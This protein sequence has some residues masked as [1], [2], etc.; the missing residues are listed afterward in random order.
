[1]KCSSFVS[2]LTGALSIVACGGGDAQ[3]TG[4]TNASAF[5]GIYQ[6]TAASENTAG[7][8][9]PGASKL[10]ELHDQFFLLAS[11]E[12]FGQKVVILTSC[13]SVADCQTKRAAQLANQP[14][15]FEYNF[16]LSSTIN[17]TTL[18]GFEAGTG[19]S[20]GTQCVE[21]TYAD[22]VLTV[23][24]DHSVQLESRSK[25]LEDQ[26]QEDGFCMVDPAKSKQE[27]ASKECGSLEVVAGSFLQAS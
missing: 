20:Q 12:F 9:A 4:V 5:E 11:S 26:P 18:N 15:Q 19:R 14:Y 7:C 24:A 1:M 25:K 16:W 23:A 13:S 22:H 21:R 8:A 6:L 2:I 10:S 27:A 3:G 17:A